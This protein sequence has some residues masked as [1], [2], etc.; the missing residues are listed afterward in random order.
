MSRPGA[1]GPHGRRTTV[2]LTGGTNDANCAQCHGA[3]GA[4]SDKGPPLVHDIDNRGHHADAAFFFAVKRGVPRHHWVFGD[5][6]PR[7]Q[8]TEDDVYAIV[9]YIQELQEENGILY[10][11][12]RM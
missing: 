5:M 1:E 4:G 11:Q 12:H 7:P 6:P 2:E 9:R 8:V 10:R 3:N